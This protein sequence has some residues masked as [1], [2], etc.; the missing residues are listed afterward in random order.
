MKYL[1][2][3]K[4]EFCGWGRLERFLFPGVIV[5][6]VLISIY[7]RDSKVALVSAICGICATILAGK[8]KI[9]C[10]L[11]GM[12]A[13]ICYSYI[14]YK[15]SFWGNLALNMLYYFPMQFVGIAKWKNHLNIETQI[16]SKTRLANNE[17]FLYFGLAFLISLIGYFVLKYFEDS[18]PIIDSFTTV[19]SIFAF[20]FTVKRCIEQWYAWTIV[21]ALCVIMWIGAYL[22]GSN[23]LATILMWI[24]YLVLGIYF[25]NNWNKE[26]KI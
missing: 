23:C 16:I 15:N 13:N 8:G 17:R 7:M 11:F 25:L 3:L 20:I 5:F 18:N 22:N 6:I 19:L 1:D 4:K 10:Y 9:S 12:I 2:F 24:T 21:N 26:V 14:S